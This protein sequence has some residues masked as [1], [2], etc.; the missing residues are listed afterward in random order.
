MQT[1]LTQETKQDGL[2]YL[3][4]LMLSDVHIPNWIDPTDPF[5]ELHL[6]RG[7]FYRFPN[8]VAQMIMLSSRAYFYG[9]FKDKGESNENKN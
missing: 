3:T 6:K 7:F 1:E 8:Q 9:L 5:K 2:N 4:I